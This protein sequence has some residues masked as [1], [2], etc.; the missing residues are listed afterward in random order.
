MIESDFLEELDV[1]DSEIKRNV[2]SVFRGEKETSYTGD[3]LVF[4]DHRSYV[5]GDDTRLIDWNLYARTDD[6]YVKQFE[7]E[8]NLTVHVLLD[9]S[10]SMDYGDASK[11]EVGAKIGLGYAYLSTAENNDFRFSVYGEGL[12]RLDD[13]SSSRGGVLRV[14]DEVNDVE[15]D[16]KADLAD[17]IDS[18]SG[19]IESKSLV[20]VVSDFVGPVRSMRESRRGGARVVRER[21]D[22]GG[23]LAS[24]SQSHVVFVQVLSPGELQLTASG[25]TVFRAVETDAEFRTYVSP[26]RRRVYD[27][28]L[29]EHV[30][31]VAA[32]VESAGGDHVL[33]DTGEDFFESF[34]KAWIGT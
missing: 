11:F 32:S 9:S 3:G 34:S 29:R 17:A 30:D 15:P 18:Y 6:Y 26:R 24:L 22:V 31:D 25:D 28:R 13:G 23:A 4:S 14:L 2:A 10:G 16:G 19:Y 1:Y 21:V 27:E 33:V 20:V 7:E 8:R 12:R 5:P